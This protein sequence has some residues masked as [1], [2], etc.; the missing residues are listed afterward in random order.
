MYGKIKI[1]TAHLVAMVVLSVGLAV[2][3]WAVDGVIEINQARAL[4]G[5]VT[6]GDDPGFPV[7]ISQPGSYRLTGNLTTGAANTHGI[8]IIV[9]NVT[10][11]LNG[12]AISGPTICVGVPLVCNPPHF[13][14]G[15]SGQVSHVSVF[16]GFVRGMSYGVAL[17][18][19]GLVQKIHAT[20][21]SSAGIITGAGSIVKYNTSDHNGNGIHG[22][23]IIVNN[24]VMSNSNIGINARG[25][26]A[27]NSVDWNH[28]I[29]IYANSSL[30]IGNSVSNNASYGIYIVGGGYGDN[31]LFHNNNDG[32]QVVGGVKIGTNVCNGTVCP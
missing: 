25:T 1:M 18:S 19:N 15:I 10:I 12:F 31:V 14:N 29:G 21:N 24:S 9:E 26:I 32:S 17:G 6:P 28:N 2:N 16:N 11:D 7:T 5:G 27:G 22:E 23:G 8:N 4:A 30:V 20:S 3:V 13:G